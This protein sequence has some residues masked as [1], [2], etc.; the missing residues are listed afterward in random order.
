MIN[1]ENEDGRKVYCRECG[2]YVGI[3]RSA[4]LMKNLKFICPKCQ[5]KQNK[6]SNE[7][8]NT[9]FGGGFR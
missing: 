3:I 8:F 9:L 6:Y 7:L 5:K 1:R 4:K 2:C